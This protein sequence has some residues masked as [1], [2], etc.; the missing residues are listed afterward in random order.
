MSTPLAVGTKAPSFKLPDASGKLHSLA[1]FAG[2][3]VVLYFYPEDDTKSCT[4]EA[5]DF[6]DS[7]PDIESKGATLIGI[8]PDSPA[9]H[10]AF[11]EKYKLT[12][13]L[14]ADI[15]GADGT[16]SVAASY[17]VWA[18]KSM[19]GKKYIGIVRTTFLIGPDGVIKNRWDNVRVEGHA[20]SVL[21]ALIP[22]A[23]HAATSKGTAKASTTGN[24]GPAIGGKPSTKP[25]KGMSMKGVRKAGK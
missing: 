7:M 25:A 24:A 9:K 10:A 14:L 4:T 2:K 21:E 5:C 18:E 15:P 16:P 11:I 6:N 23:S 22:G 8:S 1:D 17:G 12:F 3:T 19:F 13:T 20:S